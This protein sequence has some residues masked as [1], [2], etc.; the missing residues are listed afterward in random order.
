MNSVSLVILVILI[1]IPFWGGWSVIAAK[2]DLKDPIV[3]AFLV[4]VVTVVALLPLVWSRLQSGTLNSRGFWILL[5]AGVLNFGGHILFPKL[6]TMA[7]S[8]LSIYMPIIIGLNVATFALGGVLFL[9]ESITIAKVIFT[10]LIL[11]GTAGLIL[12]S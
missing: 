8:Q 7:G 5:A 11:A 1:G 4:N 10:A 3:R 12:N 2:S 6:Q 9:G